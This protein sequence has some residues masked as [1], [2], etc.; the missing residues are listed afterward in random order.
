M[1]IKVRYNWERLIENAR[2]LIREADDWL[3]DDEPYDR[4]EALSLAHRA[5]TIG[6]R[7]TFCLQR[8]K[9]RRRVWHTH[10]VPLE[11]ITL[12]IQRLSREHA[13]E[14]RDT[15]VFFADEKALDKQ[16]EPSYDI[17]IKEEEDAKES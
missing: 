2:L 8:D 15:P 11:K 5:K 13:P 17:P 1:G 10:V 3:T 6:G 16:T 4:G 9:T 14:W 12:E 7:L